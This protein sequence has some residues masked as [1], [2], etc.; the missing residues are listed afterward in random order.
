MCSAKSTSLLRC[1]D[2][3]SAAVIHGN[4]DFSGGSCFGGLGF[5]LRRD[6]DAADPNS[7]QAKRRLG[8]TPL[9]H[10]R[11]GNQLPLIPREIGEFLVGLHGGKEFGPYAL[12]LGARGWVGDRLDF[13]GC[14]QQSLAASLVG[15]RTAI[16][17]A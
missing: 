17:L 5:V 10:D 14:T 13:I 4:I 2:Q 12:G 16:P 1:D 7:R 11:A 8:L 15:D 6:A 9:R 3:R